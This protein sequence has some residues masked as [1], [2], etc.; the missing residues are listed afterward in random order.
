[1]D[2]AV[3]VD[4][5]IGK[6]QLDSSPDSERQGERDGATGLASSRIAASF[7][8]RHPPQDSIRRFTSCETD[9]RGLMEKRLRE[10][11]GK[12]RRDQEPVPRNASGRRD[13]ETEAVGKEALD[14]RAPAYSA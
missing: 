2:P 8:P 11:D 7:G 1:M 4:E 6:G 5:P 14:A 10:R 9:G 3:V 13:L 12:E